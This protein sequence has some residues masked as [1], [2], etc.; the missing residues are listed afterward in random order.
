MVTHD[1]A[2]A[3]STGDEVAVLRD[4]ELVQTASPEVLYRM[5]ADLDVARFVGEAVVIAGNA[6]G[7]LVSCALGRLDVL[8]PRITGPVRVMIRPEQI[9]VTR[10]APDAPG[11][12][13]AARA[14]VVGR[15][16][17]GPDTV[18]ALELEGSAAA[19]LS[20]RTFERDLPEP[21]ELVLLSV[22]GP[23]VT[24]P[25][26]RP[27]VVESAAATAG[28]VTPAEEAFAVSA[29]GGETPAMTGRIRVATVAAV[30]LA[31]SAVAVG[32]GGSGGDPQSIVLYSGQHPQLT[33]ALVRGFEKQ[34]GI[35]VKVRANDGVVLADQLLQEGPA[36]P[37]DV[38]FTENSPELET[39]AE[40][41]LLAKLP[42]STL[43]HA[44]RQ[45]APASGTWAP[46][47][48]RVSGLAYSPK[49]ISRSSL[50]QSVP[51]PR[52]AAVEGKDR[53]R[54]DRFG[55]PAGRR[56]RARAVR[57]GGGQAVAGRAE[58]QRAG[59]SDR[60]GRRRGG[61]Q[62]PGG[63][64]R[65][66][67]LLLVP[68]A[69]RDRRRGDAQRRLLLPRPQRRV[70]RERLGRRRAQDEQARRA[71]RPVCELPGQLT[72]GSGS[73][74][75]ATISSIPRGRASRPTRSCRRCRAWRRRRSASSS[76]ETIRR[77][78]S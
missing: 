30:V 74:A 39:L 38:Y 17:F 44:P 12:P 71:G 37:A 65:D 64:R 68:P 1:Q 31:C 2:E 66:Q 8:R 23:V 22:R 28:R 27:D 70:D 6:R 5:P 11:S 53:D 52:A 59:V 63:D 29:N 36:S 78:R 77:P 45:D 26:R 72:P 50:P 61:Q 57:G 3:L 60:R 67:P 48:L 4:G 56:S 69:H 14:R 20:A 54:A 51:R 9:V 33:D 41:G 34:T 10:L 73:S 43:Q 25:A 76:S 46:V 62:R 7:E 15:T 19:T 16:S 40:H 47:A 49:L 75:R 35:D 32:C 13:G 21:G 55:L 18:L 58:A 24:Y 42:A